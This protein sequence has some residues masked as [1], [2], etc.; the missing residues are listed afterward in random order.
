MHHPPRVAR[1]FGAALFGIDAVRVEVQ[2]ARAAGMPRAIVIGQ[3]ETEVREG[4]D[5]LKVALQ[6][7]G[8]WRREGDQ[9][10]ILNLAPAGVR[11]AGTGL[12]LPMCLAVA[13]LNRPALQRRL[14]EVLSYGEVGLD[15]RL[16][17]AAGTL[18]AA[19]T[20]RDGGFSGILVPPEAAREAAEV[21]GLRVLAV[22]D[23]GAAAAVLRG[24]ESA[25]APWPPRPPAPPPARGI[26]LADVKGQPAAR[27]ALE[28]AAAGGHNLLM[29][30]PPGSGKTLLARRL[31][32]ILPPMTRAE[33]LEVTRI[34]SAAGLVAPGSGL[35]ERRVFRAPHHSISP[36]GMIGGGAPPRP[37]EVSLAMHGVLFLDELPEFPRSV[38]ETLRQPLEDAEV[39][40]CRA[41]GR[42]RFP[43]R[44]LL[45]AAMNPCP[46]GWHGAT[47]R[48]CR[49]TPTMIER[50]R[51]RISGPLLDRIDLHV[52]VPAVGAA[53]LARARPGEDSSSVRARVVAA[54]RLEERRNARFGVTWN[55]HL[56]A[57]HLGEACPLTPAARRALDAAMTRLG[58]SA[59]A[60]DRILKVART[61]ADLAGAEIIDVSHVGEA[62]SYRTLDRPAF[63]DD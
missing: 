24:D 61:I 14:G 12:D 48:R 47:L 36:A 41:I 60:H 31:P 26:D 8:L 27:R 57:R 5:R 55:A 25:L 38:L 39:T 44:F 35:I 59:R 56:E 15:G 34:H 23:L 1:A 19:I 10:V 6:A 9:A 21:D 20:A 52:E 3:A 11:K 16:R 32:T 42:A 50:Y 40:I 33:A 58:L 30:G 46:C 7:A 18:S 53:D 4:R 62:V 2:A 51:G 43:A 45:A 17:A 22:S 28:V 63:P 54:R 13:A 29:I 37:G 49:C